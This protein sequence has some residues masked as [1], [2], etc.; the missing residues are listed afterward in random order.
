MGGRLLKPITVS[1]LRRRGVTKK[2]TEQ[3][4]LFYTE[5]LILETWSDKLQGH[6]G[7][8]VWNLNSYIS[9]IFV[10]KNVHYLI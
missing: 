7:R 3:F 10:D 9:R 8:A 5:V 4:S 2:R 6:M 1:R